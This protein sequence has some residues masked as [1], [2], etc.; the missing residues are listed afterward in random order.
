M[1]KVDALLPVMLPSVIMAVA[2]NYGI[3]EEEAIE[4]FY[5]SNT[6]A[7][8]ED[9]DSGLWRLSDLAILD[10]YDSEQSGHMMIPEVF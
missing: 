4:R 2:E 6:Y 9:A 7:L 8:L 3:S 5:G 10:V 1:I